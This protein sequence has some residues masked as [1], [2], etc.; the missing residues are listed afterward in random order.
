[1]IKIGD[2]VDFIL[3]NARFHGTVSYI[4]EEEEI[5]SVEGRRYKFAYIFVLGFMFPFRMRQDRV[6]LSGDQEK[7]F[8]PQNSVKSNESIEHKEA[9]WKHV[10]TIPNHK[11]ETWGL[12][13]HNSTS[14]KSSWSDVL[15]GMGEYFAKTL[16]NDANGGHSCFRYQV[17]SPSGEVFELS[18]KS[19]VR[20]ESHCKQCHGAYSPIFLR[21]GL[22]F[23]C[24]LTELDRLITVARAAEKLVNTPMNGFSY[25]QEIEYLIQALR[26]AN[27]LG[28]TKEHRA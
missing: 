27:R 18:H 6:A 4:S 13:R 24:T 26:D 11:A 2:Q 20:V 17:V 3:N 8:K 9:A 14:G 7:P 15:T 5:P 19:L 22:C 10:F 16:C 1:M 25:S 23:N 21:R 28:I 12:R